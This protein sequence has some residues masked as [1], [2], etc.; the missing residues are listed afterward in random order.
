MKNQEQKIEQPTKKIA[1]LKQD[2]GGQRPKWII[3]A[4][5]V[6]GIIILGAVV[7]VGYNYWLKPTISEEQ[8]LEEQQEPDEFADWKTYSNDKYKV[9]FMYPPNFEITIDE[10]HFEYPDDKDW[11]RLEISDVSIFE[12]PKM[13]LEVNPDGY[14][15]FSPSKI[16]TVK[17]TEKGEIEIEDTT[18]KE[19]PESEEYIWI[20]PD[21]IHSRNGNTYFIQFMFKQGGNDFEPIFKQILSTFKFIKPEENSVISKVKPT[22]NTLI[23]P[24]GKMTLKI[25]SGA[26]TSDINLKITVI[27]QEE[28]NL[29][30]IGPFYDVV[31]I[32]GGKLELLKPITIEIVYDPNLLPEKAVEEKTDIGIVGELESWTRLSASADIVKHTITASIEEARGAYGSNS[33]GFTV[34]VLPIY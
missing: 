5:I 24:D 19:S 10:V 16:Y 26:V 20:I 22:G 28:L 21:I 15:P 32:G 14:G 2:G 12:N 31:L 17:E 29:G 11:Y 3:P 34:G 9:S 23:S 18:P 1:S 4:I 33:G 8:P 25:P 7:W 13:W 30:Q 27:P 6:A